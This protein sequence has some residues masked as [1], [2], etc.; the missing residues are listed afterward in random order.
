MKVNHSFTLDDNQLRAISG[1]RRLATRVEVRAYI[2]QIFSEALG[3]GVVATPVPARSRAPRARP[4]PSN[5]PSNGGLDSVVPQPP[6]P[7]PVAA[8]AIPACNS[9]DHV[10]PSGP[11]SWRPNPGTPCQCG[12]HKW[13]MA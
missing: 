9:F 10:Y 2:D 13:G 6:V 8:R 5:V 1:K 4:V 3:G 12:R 7:S 11:G